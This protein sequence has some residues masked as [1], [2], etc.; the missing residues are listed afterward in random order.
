MIKANRRRVWALVASGAAIYLVLDF[1]T[2]SPSAAPA[3]VAAPRT[4]VAIELAPKA[5]APLV[6]QLREASAPMARPA[7]ARDL[8][9]RPVVAPEAPTVANEAAEPPSAAI[10]N[11][12]LTGV[13]LGPNASAVIDGQPL[14]LGAELDGY[15][16]TVIRRNFVVFA[17][18]AERVQLRLQAHNPGP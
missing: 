8:F 1:T 12:R 16:L 10:H 2:G 9:L 18:G 15:R 4:R 3:A 11:R 13:L 6:E 14:S 5:L 7:M 17:R